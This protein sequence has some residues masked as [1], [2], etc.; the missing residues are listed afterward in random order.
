MGSHLRCCAH[1]TLWR[2]MRA[3]RSEHNAPRTARAA[4]GSFSSVLRRR[5]WVH[6][7]CAHSQQ[8]HGMAAAAMKA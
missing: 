6:E 3:A 8:H 5:G 7:R 2:A 4:G 1:F